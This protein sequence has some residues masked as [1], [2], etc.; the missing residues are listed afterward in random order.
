MA[1]SLA[2]SAGNPDLASGMGIVRRGNAASWTLALRVAFPS[3]RN[4]AGD[5]QSFPDNGDER[6]DAVAS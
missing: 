1:S 3:E 5:A 2:L 4:P 6:F